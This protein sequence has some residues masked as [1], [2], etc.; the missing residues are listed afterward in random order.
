M[1]DTLV[2]YA[3]YLFFILLAGVAIGS[4]VAMVAQ[5]SPLYSAINLIGVFVALAGLYL[6]LA[7]P[8]I[9]VVQILSLIHI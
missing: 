1:L 9:A 2:S 8:F 3:P 7:A 4:A 5:R 6:T